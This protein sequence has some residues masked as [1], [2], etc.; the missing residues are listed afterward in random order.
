MDN[1]APNHSILDTLRT[2][3]FRLGLK[4]YNVDEVDEYLEKAAVEAEQ[5]QERLR[6]ANERLRQATERIAQLEADAGGARPERGGTLEPAP[7]PGASTTVSGSGVSD[8]T[9][10]RTLLLAQKF[11]EETKRES[12]AEAAQVVSR[13]EERAR[14]LLAQAEERARRIT[15]EAEDRLRAEVARLEEA[16]K[17]LSGDVEA[18][19]RHLAEQ[20]TKI[21]A[22]LAE[23]LRW[24]DE[25]MQDLSE[26]GEGGEPRPEEAAGRR[27][28]AATASGG[29]RTQIPSAPLPAQRSTPRP[30][31]TPAMGTASERQAGGQ[32]EGLSDGLAT[33]EHQ[34]HHDRPSDRSERAAGSRLG[35]LNGGLF[36]AG[37]AETSRGQE[38]HVS[39]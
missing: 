34:S 8:D 14:T 7:G 27:P 12:E 2:V 13:A 31:L 16:R 20:R 29:Q 37:S 3:E 10:Q 24:I 22:S 33:N 15:T 30:Q 21:R 26:D 5:V 11:V 9:L 39:E 36:D 32:S 17:R 25:R 1:S 18:M 6:T 19:S 38:A 4:G 35:V 23:A 28:T